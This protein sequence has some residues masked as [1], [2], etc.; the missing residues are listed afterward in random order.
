MR[1]NGCK[2]NHTQRLTTNRPLVFRVMDERDPDKIR[3][4]GERVCSLEEIC[5][6]D[7][8]VALP[9]PLHAAPAGGSGEGGKPPPRLEFSLLEARKPSFLDFVRG[10]VGLSLH[11]GVDFTASNG[12]PATDPHSLHA[13]GAGALGGGGRVVH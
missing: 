11:V 12:D 4:M 2:K 10:G 13:L 6:R 8:R 3:L 5:D 9:L 1:Q 7:G